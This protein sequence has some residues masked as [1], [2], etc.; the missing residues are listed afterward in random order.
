M[1]FVLPFAAS[2]LHLPAGVGGAWIGTSEFADAAGFAA[3]QTYGAVAEHGQRGGTQD[4]AVWAFTLM[5]VVGRD[6]RIGIW[7]FVMALIAS[8]PA[9]RASLNSARSGGAFQ[10]SSS[11]SSSRR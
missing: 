11:A 6:V 2:V 4:Q 9:S 7:A 5:K 3:A 10:N 1:I 8:T